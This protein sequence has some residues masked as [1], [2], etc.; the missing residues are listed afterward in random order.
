M[1]PMQISVAF[2]VI[3]AF[4]ASSGMAQTDYTFTGDHNDQWTERLNW[5]PNTDYPKGPDS[6][7]IPSGKTCVVSQQ[8]AEIRTLTVD[9]TLGV[10]GW[11]LTTW[12]RL[13]V[14][15]TLYMKDGAAGNTATLFTGPNLIIAGTGAIDASKPDYGPALIEGNSEHRR[16]LVV[17]AGLTLKGSIQIREVKLENNATFLVDHADD[18]MDIGVDSD[19]AMDVSGSGTFKVTAGL[20]KF[21]STR[22]VWTFVGWCR[23][24]GGIMRFTDEMAFAISQGRFTVTGGILDI[25]DFLGTNGSLSFSGGK[26]EL[27]AGKSAVFES[28]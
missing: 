22:L 14:N 19:L 13:T 23:V 4:A 6:A 28:P 15:G 27:A 3:L 8:D 25:D 20:L 17:N 5:I 7:T 10:E 16:D 26:I 18:V 21:R 9:G 11:K 12:Y 2:L 24:T 1:K